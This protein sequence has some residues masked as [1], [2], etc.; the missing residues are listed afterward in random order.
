MQKLEERRR[1]IRARQTRWAAGIAN[2]LARAGLKP[3]AISLLS[4]VFALG[5]A[6]CFLESTH[7]PGGGQVFLLILGAAFIQMRLLCNLFDGMVAVE[8]GLQS[9]S[10]EIYNEL[11]DRISDAAILVAAGYSTFWIQWEP[12]LGWTCA[13]LSVLTAYVRTLGALAGAGQQFCGPMAKQQRMFIIT[14]AALFTA[15]EVAMHQPNR[16]MAIALSI[17]ACGCIVTIARRTLR[18]LR[19]LET[20]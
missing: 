10:G 18:V 9:K 12:E 1:P 8:E 4:I 5:S 19:A 15:S 11:P 7:H 14:A 20:T 17:V 6:Y 2:F 13:L 16:A 3:N